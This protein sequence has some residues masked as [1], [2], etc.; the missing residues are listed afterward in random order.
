MKKTFLISIAALL[1]TSCQAPL[2]TAHAAACH[3]DCGPDG[4]N[5]EYQSDIVC[6]KYH[7]ELWSEQNCPLLD[8]CERDVHTPYLRLHPERMW[9]DKP[10]EL[11][12]KS[13]DLY[14]KDKKCR[15]VKGRRKPQEE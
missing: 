5:W 12:V 6:G 1:L 10:H 11:I 15:L 13:G 4:E 14:Y 9:R 3:P 7:G 2:R 8:G